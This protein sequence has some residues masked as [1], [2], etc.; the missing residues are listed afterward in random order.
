MCA[1]QHDAQSFLL[2]PLVTALFCEHQGL[3]P[4]LSSKVVSFYNQSKILHF[5]ELQGIGMNMEIL[6]W[7]TKNDTYA[8]VG[9]IRHLSLSY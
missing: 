7:F 8:K 9:I 1:V 2:N 5:W 4:H 6:K 3:V